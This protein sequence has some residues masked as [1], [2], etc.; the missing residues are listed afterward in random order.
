MATDGDGYGYD[1][2]FDYDYD[3]DYD[4]DNAQAAPP[5]LCPRRPGIRRRFGPLVNN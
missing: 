1:H 4:D 3:C 2:G 5:R